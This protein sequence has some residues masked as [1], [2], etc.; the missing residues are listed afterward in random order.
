MISS[1]FTHLKQT[2]KQYK[3]E[4]NKQQIGCIMTHA[5]LDQVTQEVLEEKVLKEVEV[6]VDVWINIEYLLDP[7]EQIQANQENIKK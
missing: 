4:F 1:L 7:T 2:F 6:L 3:E 5:D